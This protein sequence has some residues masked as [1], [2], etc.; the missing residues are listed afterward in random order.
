MWKVL[1]YR[2]LLIISLCDLFVQTSH[3]GSFMSEYW[4]RMES[5]SIFYKNSIQHSETDNPRRQT[6]PNVI[7]DNRLYHDISVR[8]DRER[9]PTR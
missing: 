2:T 4:E 9:S 6:W 7:L 8:R 3:L 1:F 5:L